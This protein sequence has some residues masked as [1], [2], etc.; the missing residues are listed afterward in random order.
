MLLLA[1]LTIFRISRYASLTVLCKSRMVLTYLADTLAV[2]Q[3]VCDHF[4][5]LREMPAIPLSATHY[6]IIKFFV[7]VIQKS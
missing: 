6:V 7:E 4:S 3:V 2:G 5:Q 1:L